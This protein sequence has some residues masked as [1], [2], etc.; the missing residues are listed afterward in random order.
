M[1]KMNKTELSGWVKAKDPGWAE[2][3]FDHATD[4]GWDDHDDADSSSYVP[5]TNIPPPSDDILD[6]WR[7]ANEVN[8]HRRH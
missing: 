5:P 4:P 7:K 3:G 2:D 6:K 1:S 8:I